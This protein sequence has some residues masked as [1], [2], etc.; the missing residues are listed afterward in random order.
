MRMTLKKIEQYLILAVLFLL[1]WQTRYILQYGKLGGGPWEYGTFSIYGVEILV[2]III[3]LFFIRQIREKKWWPNFLLQKKDMVLPIIF[4]LLMG[5][6]L[7]VSENFWVSYQYV[8]RWLGAMSFAI[9]LGSGIEGYKRNLA[10]LWLGG[11]PQ[12]LLAV[13][14]FLTQHIFANKWLGMA[15]QEAMQGGASVVEFGDERWLRAYGSFGSPNSLAI[16]LAVLLVLGFIIYFKT[17]H[18]VLKIFITVGQL[19]ITSGL[20]LS[21]S[22]GAWV[23]ATVGMVVLFFVIFFAKKDWRVFFIRQSIFVAVLTGFWVGV[24]YP[25]F[26]ARFNTQNRLEAR[27]ISERQGQYIES[28]YFIKQSPLFG[29]GPGVYTFILA[30]KYP[31]LQF[32]QLQPVHNIYI[33]SIVEFGIFFTVSLG[34]IVLNQ[35]RR[36]IKNNLIFLPI[37]GTI[38]TAGLFDHWL[39]SMFSGLLLWWVIWTL[40]IEKI[41]S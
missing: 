35:I 9:I 11:V 27:S 20:L 29:A 30:R 25:V 39:F 5:L 21:F 37:L 22:R 40:S 10:A 18:P 3:L 12:G 6:S 19:V 1:P 8:F 14:Q 36:V 28:L 26:N 13:Y 17:E 34:L 38:L 31:E 23:A 41:D 33:L 24:F 16:Y 32:W 15:A 2:W 4:L 7:A